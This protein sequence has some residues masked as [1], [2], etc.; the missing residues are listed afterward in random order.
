MGTLRSLQVQHVE[1]S[2]DNEILVC[3]QTRYE[4]DPPPLAKGDFVYIPTSLYNAVDS[5]LGVPLDAIVSLLVEGFG[6]L[7]IGDLEVE[8]VTGGVK[9]IHAR[10]PE[11]PKK[12]GGVRR[13]TL[14][15]SRILAV[16]EA[17][18]QPKGTA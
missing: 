15:A 17:Y 1:D 16:G 12:L 8:L 7:E 4:E 3:L 10:L 6:W 18:P 2:G 11:P 14:S 5:I 9:V 13:L